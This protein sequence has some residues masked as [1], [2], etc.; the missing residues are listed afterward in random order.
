[1]KRSEP[2]SPSD[3]GRLLAERRARDRVS[4]RDAAE[5]MGLS[6][7]T[8]ARVEKGRVPDV[9]TF[10]RI[11]E[12]I[13]LS[14]ADFFQAEA[15]RVESTPDAIASHLSA[16]PALTDEAADKIASIVTELYGALARRTGTTAVHLR[17]ARALPADAAVRLADLVEQMNRSLER[18]HAAR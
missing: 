5:K 13:G 9:Q 6:F 2:L 11:A 4:L 15:H 18:E 8:L 10:Q 12:W 14:P 1:M 7:N 3:L 16:D 17:S